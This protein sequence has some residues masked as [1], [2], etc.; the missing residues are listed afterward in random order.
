MITVVTIKLLLSYPASIVKNSG[1]A[2][3]I[4]VLYASLLAFVLFFIT[5]KAYKF[6]KDIITLAESIGKKPLKI[7]VG[8]A[9][10]FVLLFNFSIV[11]RMFPESVKVIM[12]QDNKIE[13]ILIGFAVVTA[14]GAYMGIHSIS[15][16][17][18]LF[19]PIAGIVF[20]GFLLLLLPYC[21]IQNIMPILGEGPKN[22]FL[23]GINSLAIFSDFI[24]L[25]IF[26]P[27]MKNLDDTKKSGKKSFIISAAAAFL[28]VLAYCL[29]YEYPASADYLLPMYQLMKM[30]HISSFFSRFEAFFQFIWSILVF[31]YSS[32][33]VFAMCRVLQKTFSLKFYKPLIIPLVLISTAIAKLPDSISDTVKFAEKFNLIQIPIVFF[34]PLIICLIA[35]SIYR[36]ED[37]K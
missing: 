17:S 11:T 9:V 28:T 23:N 32:A 14:I 8:L 15:R 1:Q 5:S 24:L 10:F 30:I 33:Y 21:N 12:L 37:K 7:I 16:I 31:L 27:D 22:L 26:I 19:L 36:K 2:A 34:L 3:W 25:N 13:S 20:V 4:E 18:F 35:I 6:K 29:N